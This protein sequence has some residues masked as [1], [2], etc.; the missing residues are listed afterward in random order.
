MIHH[1]TF[2]LDRTKKSLASLQ[3][4][5]IELASAKQLVPSPTTVRNRNMNFPP[6][7]LDSNSHLRPV[8]QPGEQRK[9]RDQPIPNSYLTENST[10]SQISNEVKRIPT[11]VGRP[12]TNGLYC[13]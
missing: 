3:S 13:I 10:K 6:P 7:P 8:D 1:I 4:R 9:S 11:A 12:L 5:F 2:L